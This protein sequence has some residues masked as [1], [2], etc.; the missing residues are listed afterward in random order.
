MAIQLNFVKLLRTDL[1]WENHFLQIKQPDIHS[2]LR[3]Y[4]F[5]LLHYT[6]SYLTICPFYGVLICLQSEL[7]IIITLM[8]KVILFFPNQKCI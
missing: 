1:L 8:D 3:L 2:S 7:L 6:S 4:T 5:L